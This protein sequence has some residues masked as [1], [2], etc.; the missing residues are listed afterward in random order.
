[1]FSFI[2]ILKLIAELINQLLE[3][4]IVHCNNQSLALSYLRTHSSMII[5]ISN[6]I[7]REIKF[8]KEL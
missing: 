7:S 6:T 5:L 2:W 8:S 4:T 3:T 1:M